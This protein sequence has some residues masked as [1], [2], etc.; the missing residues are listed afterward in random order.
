MI[1]LKN[2]L[3]RFFKKD[4][5]PKHKCSRPRPGN[6]CLEQSRDQDHGLEY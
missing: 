6:S 4:Q 3:D 2:R 1:C 5:D